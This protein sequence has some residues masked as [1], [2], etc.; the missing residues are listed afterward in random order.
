[1]TLEW[2]LV[3]AKTKRKNIHSKDRG[4]HGEPPV[5]RVQLACQTGG[6]VFVM[7]FLNAGLKSFKWSPAKYLLST[8]G[9]I[10]TTQ[11]GIPADT[12][13]PRWLRLIMRN[14]YA[15]N[16]LLR[17]LEKEVTYC[18]LLAKNAYSYSNQETKITETQTR[19][20]STRYIVNNLQKYQHHERHG[21]TEY[22]IVEETLWVRGDWLGKCN[23]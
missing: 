12:T 13:L 5:A 4:G 2:L 8:K 22:T 19:R 14:I 7:P 17:F 23:N 10:V 1:M 15:I 6:H 3:T 9:K 21:K 20:Y 16:P 11:W 18:D